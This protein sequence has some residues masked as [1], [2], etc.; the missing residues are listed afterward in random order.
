MSTI[1]AAKSIISAASVRFIPL[2]P[3]FEFHSWR[4]K[5]LRLIRATLLRWSQG[6]Q[7]ISAQACSPAPELA[8]PYFAQLVRG[9]PRRPTLPRAGRTRLN[10]HPKS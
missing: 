5:R 3:F 9:P 1:E 10:S 2:S 6:Q 7:E 8:F 4:V